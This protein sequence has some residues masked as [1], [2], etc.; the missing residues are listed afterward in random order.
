MN[1]LH[2]PDIERCKKLT[3]IGFPFS[4]LNR[5]FYYTD[6]VIAD[7]TYSDNHLVIGFG[8]PSVMELLDLIPENIDTNKWLLME[9]APKAYMVSYYHEDK[10]SKRTDIKFCDTLPNALCDLIFWLVENKYITFASK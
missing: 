1:K 2:Y 6:W 4:N 3:E 5:L 8:C 9:K 10:W 7:T